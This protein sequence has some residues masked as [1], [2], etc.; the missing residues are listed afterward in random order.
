MPGINSANT[1]TEGKILQ[2]SV[3]N[4]SDSQQTLASSIAAD[5]NRIRRLEE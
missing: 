1:T 2:S 5:S 4:Q 3:V